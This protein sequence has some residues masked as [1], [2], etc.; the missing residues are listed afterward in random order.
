MQTKIE[1][2]RIAV[3][4]AGSGVEQRWQYLLNPEEFHEKWSNATFKTRREA[5]A[6]ATYSFDRC[7][8]YMGTTEFK[9]TAHGRYDNTDGATIQVFSTPNHFEEIAMRRNYNGG[10]EAYDR[11]VKPAYGGAKILWHG[12]PMATCQRWNQEIWQQFVAYLEAQYANN[13]VWISNYRANHPE[14]YAD[15]SDPIGPLVLPRPIYWHES[16]GWTNDLVEV[17]A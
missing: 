12:G 10:D 5:E 7:P 6:A 4:Y 1:V 8:Y 15:P 9:V 3:S 17:T 2:R 11:Q 13:M 14:L 16:N